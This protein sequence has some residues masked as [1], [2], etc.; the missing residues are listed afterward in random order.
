[1]VGWQYWHYC[2]CN[3]PTTTGAGDTQALVLD[4][5]APPEG[6]NVK[7][8]K[9]LVLARP[10][11]QA[12]AGTPLRWDFDSDTRLFELDYST[13]RP[14]GGGS[15]RPGSLTEVFVG[16]RHY[17]G[18]YVAEVSG[19]QVVSAPNAEVLLV[20]SVGRANEVSVRVRPR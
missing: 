1:M 4:P 2:P 6:S 11:P 5:A 14:G 13:D 3:D 7:W 18:G 12:V 19:G 8:E 9:L 20:R 10:Y 15:F 16:H 17:P